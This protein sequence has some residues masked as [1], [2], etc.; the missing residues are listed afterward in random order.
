M[1]FR[2]FDR[3]LEIAW[4]ALLGKVATLHS[5]YGSR[6]GFG[7]V[8]C[9]GTYRGA[10]QSISIAMSYGGYNRGG[11]GRGSYGGGGGFKGG[12]RGER[13]SISFTNIYSQL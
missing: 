10:E 11:W 4:G 3:A 5:L 6:P 12:R 13:M 1:F 7:I 2:P 8:A 9:Q